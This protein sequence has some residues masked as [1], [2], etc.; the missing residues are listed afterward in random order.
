MKQIVAVSAFALLLA[1]GIAAVHAAPRGGGPSGASPNGPPTGLPPTWQGSN[2]PGF[3]VPVDRPGWNGGTEPPGWGSGPHPPWMEWWHRSTR[4][5][6]EVNSEIYR[7]R[8]LRRPRHHSAVTKRFP[9]PIGQSG[10]CLV[11]F[12]VTDAKTAARLVFED[13]ARE[14]FEIGFHRPTALV[15]HGRIAAIPASQVAFLC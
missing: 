10:K 9:P 11:S 12:I 5:R 7:G 8:Q 15:Q 4:L 6:Q 3:S 2:P 1:F 13:E 14:T